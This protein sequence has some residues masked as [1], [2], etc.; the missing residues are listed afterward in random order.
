MRRGGLKDASSLNLST[1]TGDAGMAAQQ[2]RMSHVPFS[3]RGLA[4]A[5]N[6]KFLGHRQGIDLLVLV[7]SV[8]MHNVLHDVLLFA[9]RRDQ[10]LVT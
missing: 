1:D 2:G 5:R 10:A 3:P 4:P 6:I 8:M 9:M 7:L